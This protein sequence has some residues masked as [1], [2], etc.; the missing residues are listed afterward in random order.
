MARKKKKQKYTKD[1]FADIICAKCGLCLD[2]RANFC[3]VMYKKNHARFF[4]HSYPKL[5]KVGYWPHSKSKSKKLFKKIFCTS[6]ACGKK[7]KGGK[8]CKDISSCMTFFYPSAIVLVRAGHG[9][10]DEMTRVLG[11]AKRARRRKKK[12]K[13]EKF[14]VAAYPTFFCSDD[15][16]W[17][18]EIREALY[19]KD[20]VEK[21]D[22]GSE[23]A[24]EPKRS[25]DGNTDASQSC[26]R[27]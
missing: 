25:S 18:K 12:K 21:Q 7:K 26:L 24:E 11:F 5:L 23:S 10:S 14:V 8:K 17:K 27:V 3:Y 1:E 2:D 20:N 13:K 22:R 19:G 6:G 9:I 16:Q 15:E 4:E